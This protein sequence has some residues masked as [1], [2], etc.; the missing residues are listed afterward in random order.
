L[1]ELEETVR[2]TITLYNRL[3]S[4]EAVARLVTVLPEVVIVSFSGS[5]CYSCGVPIDYIKGFVS[6]FR[7]FSKKVD[8]EIGR[9]RETSP[10]SFEV[11]YRVR[12]R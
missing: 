6:Y 10:G 11:E 12:A 8:L 4:P 1:S 2:K 5:F 9:T 7:I 3:R